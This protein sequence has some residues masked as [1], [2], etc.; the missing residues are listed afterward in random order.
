MQLSLLKTSVL[1]LAL[2]TLFVGCSSESGG[3][4]G[5]RSAYD[6]LP[7]E[8]LAKARGED[9]HIPSYSNRL[10]FASD[11]PADQKRAIED[12]VS[13]L[14][15]NTFKGGQEDDALKYLIGKDYLSGEVL[16]S[17]LEARAQYILPSTFNTEPDSDRRSDFPF[18]TEIPD[19]SSSV[20]SAK[21][22]GTALMINFGALVYALGKKKGVQYNV[23]ISGFGRV[24][25]KSPRTGILMIQE[26]LFSLLPAEH[27]QNSGLAIFRAGVLFHEARHS[28]GRGKLAGFFH[29]KCPTGHSLEGVNACDA[30]YNGPYALGALVHKA[31]QKAC[32]DC[33]ERSNA[34][35]DV[36][37]LD[38]MNRVNKGVGPSGVTSRLW[39]ASP[40]GSR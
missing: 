15:L 32:V 38:N 31:L 35:L 30:N 13:M 27:I 9:R 1:A 5:S 33:S 10:R 2:T 37:Y 22:K 8:L 3:N 39:D 4:S 6:G 7:E 25:V 20:A 19:M 16:Q 26:G 34:V 21:S 28:D 40:E 24:P 29:A 12:A 11:V 36:I 17:W 18:P 14:Y 23:D